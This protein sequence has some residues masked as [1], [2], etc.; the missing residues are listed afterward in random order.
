MSGLLKIASCYMHTMHTLQRHI[1]RKYLEIRD[2]Y[3]VVG[4]E[5]LYVGIRRNEDD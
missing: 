5:V 1:I 4:A 3:Q 2:D